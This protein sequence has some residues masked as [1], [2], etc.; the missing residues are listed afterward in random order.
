[1]IVTYVGGP[2][3]GQHERLDEVP[4]RKI[5]VDPATGEEFLY[6]IRQQS[7]GSAGNNPIVWSHTTYGPADMS[8]IDFLKLSR[9]VIP[10]LNF[11]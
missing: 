5:E 10:P 7:G 4:N 6:E 11:E 2:R 9:E 3:H 1:M 8:T